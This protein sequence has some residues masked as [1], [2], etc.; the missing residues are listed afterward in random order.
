MK[1]YEKKWL[2]SCKL[3]DEEELEQLCKMV[4][5]GEGGA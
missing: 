2:E 1:T 4:G 5:I 3:L